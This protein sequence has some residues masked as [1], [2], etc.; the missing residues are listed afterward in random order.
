MSDNQDSEI[1][2]PPQEHFK[3]LLI[4][5]KDISKL[6]TDDPDYK[7]FICNL[8][9]Y[10]EISTSSDKFLE[11]MADKMNI[12]YFEERSQ[13]FSLHTQSIWST[14][15]YIYELIHIDLLPK[16]IPEDIYNGVAN[17]IKN[18]LQHIFGNAIMIKTQVPQDKIE[19][20]CVDCTR[21]DLSD[22]LENRIRHI[23]VK[24]DDD[25]DIGEFN[26][27]YEDP[28]KFIEEFMIQDHKFVEKSFL[29]HNLQIYYTP[30]NN[31]NMEKLIGEGY[32]QLLIMT[33]IT[34]NY[35]GNFTLEEFNS[36]IK[37]LKSECPLECPLE[38]KKP[39]NELEKKL[40]NE[41]RKFIFNKYRALYKAINLFTS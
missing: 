22:L 3:F 14:S 12:K 30:G 17:L 21:K 16:D 11:L 40:K 36:I 23:G 9:I 8:D 2:L 13:P 35:Y 24:V 37:L 15:K 18:D 29:L 20:K 5:T 19:I 28:T 31:K 6:R 4:K 27:Y 7:H 34:D 10:E 33:K 38:W 26:W 25:G 41:K 39:S 32:E 1:F